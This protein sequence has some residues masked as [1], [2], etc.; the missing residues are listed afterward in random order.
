MKKYRMY[1]QPFEEFDKRKCVYETEDYY[2]LLENMNDIA[3]KVYEEQ[4]KNSGIQIVD[5]SLV[6]VYEDGSENYFKV[7][8]IE[9]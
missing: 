4:F 5:F 9:A 3:Y 6:E 8:Y 1:V 2:W 7:V